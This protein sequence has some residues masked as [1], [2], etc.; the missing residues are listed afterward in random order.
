MR[1]VEGDAMRHRG[2]LSARER[3]ARS[4]L[5]NLLRQ[6]PLLRAGLVTMARRCGKQGCKC[7]RGEK[8][9]SLYLSVR[10]RG[11]RKMVYV[12]QQLEEQV[13]AWVKTYRE[14]EGHIDV[15][16]EACMERLLKKKDELSRQKKGKRGKE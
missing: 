4:Q 14:V 7:T 12:P 16:S 2:Y 6:R 13:R 10:L 3:A 8:H 9:V 15:V 5:V 11:K 1:Y